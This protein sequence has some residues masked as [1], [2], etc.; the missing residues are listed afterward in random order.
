[1]DNISA[2]ASQMITTAICDACAKE[3]A[4]LE[5]Q[6]QE[7][8]GGTGQDQDSGSAGLTAAGVKST[9]SS[10]DPLDDIS[11]VASEITA[12]AVDAARRQGQG[13]GVDGRMFKAKVFYFILRTTGSSFFIGK[14][15]ILQLQIQKRA[16]R[17]L[18]L[19]L[20][21]M[22]LES[23]ESKVR[24]LPHR[25]TQE[26]QVQVKMDREE[27]PLW[28]WMISAPKRVR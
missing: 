24:C 9:P 20:R 16:L 8:G 28:T 14:V 27:V 7:G 10:F 5:G 23:E 13:P 11:A 1:V 21:K 12:A 25:L 18:R 4:E 6:K 19:H 22:A 26:V 17:V 2:K 3:T 15:S